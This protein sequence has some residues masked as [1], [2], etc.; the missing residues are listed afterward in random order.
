MLTE[1]E[2]EQLALAEQILAS[3]PML[4]LMAGSNH[5]EAQLQAIRPAW[6]KWAALSGGFKAY[7]GLAKRVADSVD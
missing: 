6:Q 7:N 4:W 1:K 5:T 2:R 3:E